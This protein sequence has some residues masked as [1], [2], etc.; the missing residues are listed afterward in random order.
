[1]RCSALAAWARSRA[2]SP[3]RA[4]RWASRAP[5]SASSWARPAA[6][7]LRKLLLLAQLRPQLLLLRRRLVHPQV[8][9]HRGITGH[10]VTTV[11]PVLIVAV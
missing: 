3:S 2:T 5:S 7:R 10:L 6:Q 8:H 1:M 9:M 4:A 11:W